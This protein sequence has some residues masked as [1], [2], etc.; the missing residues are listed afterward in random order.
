MIELGTYTL[1]RWFC[2]NVQN[3]IRHSALHSWHF[4]PTERLVSLC[5]A[6]MAMNSILSVNRGCTCASSCSERMIVLCT[7]FQS[8]CVHW[9]TEAAWV[10]LFIETVDIEIVQRTKALLSSKRWSHRG[11]KCLIFRL[12]VVSRLHKSHCQ[13]KR[14]WEERTSGRHG[15]HYSGETK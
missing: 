2:C 1:L 4:L 7:S 12:N 6:Y 14:R 10:I 8:W 5:H 3:S 13:L 9:G 11:N 15:N